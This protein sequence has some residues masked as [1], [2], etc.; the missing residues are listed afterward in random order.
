MLIVALKMESLP[1]DVRVSNASYYGVLNR[2]NFM[3]LA[4]VLHIR[5]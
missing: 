5:P 3:A 2:E 1:H 4:S